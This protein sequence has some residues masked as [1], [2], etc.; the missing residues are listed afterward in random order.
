MP[1]TEQY[2]EFTITYNE[3]S[4]KFEAKDSEGNIRRSKNLGKLRELLYAQTKPKKLN[5]PIV[6]KSYRNDEFDA[7]T[8]TSIAHTVGYNNMKEA[9]VTFTKD[10]S[11]KKVSLAY[12]ILDNEANQALITEILEKQKEMRAID[13]QISELEDRFERYEPTGD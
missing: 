1:M 11:R 7:A 3:T 10:K 2:G 12:I 4:E 8:L 9:W 5:V 13:G 6:I